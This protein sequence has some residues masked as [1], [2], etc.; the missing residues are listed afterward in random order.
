MDAM[1]EAFKRHISKH[2][3]G[4]PQPEMAEDP[5]EKFGKGDDEDMVSDNDPNVKSDHAPSLL[6]GG[7]AMGM[8]PMDGGHEDIIAL[9]RKALMGVGDHVGRSAM[10]LNEKAKE[11][12][13]SKMHSK[14]V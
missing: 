13:L 7:D 10:G 8:H 4:H 1:K 3:K 2:A 6:H 14:K 9:I 5:T 12:M 11:S